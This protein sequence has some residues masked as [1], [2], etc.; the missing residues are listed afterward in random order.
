M[1]ERK[2]IGEAQIK[3]GGLYTHIYTHNTYIHTNMSTQNSEE[4][5]SGSQSGRSEEEDDESTLY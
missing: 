3:L 2:S 5:G 4:L 1:R